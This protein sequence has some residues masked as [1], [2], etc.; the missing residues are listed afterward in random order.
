MKRE[1]EMM[2]SR[3]PGRPL[4]TQIREEVT[5]GLRDRF[6][7]SANEYQS[8]QKRYMFEIEEEIRDEIYLGRPNVLDE[9]ITA[10]L[11]NPRNICRPSSSDAYTI[12]VKEFITPSEL[13]KEVASITLKYPDWIAMYYSLEELRESLYYYLLLAQ[14]KAERS[15]KEAVSIP[16]RVHKT[17]DEPKN[18]SKAGWLVYRYR[19]YCLV[20]PVV[21]AVILIIYLVGLF[22]RK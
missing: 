22:G 13:E 8:A 17:E 16:E 7:G 9:G 18:N 11:R 4:I 10:A 5:R 6:V 12:G 19:Y 3:N 15:A 14:T 20:I 21:G 2:S 1:T